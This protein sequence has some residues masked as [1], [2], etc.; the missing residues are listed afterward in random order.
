[1]L[2]QRSPTSG[3]GQAGG[4]PLV[5]DPEQRAQ[6]CDA[7]GQPQDLPDHDLR[8]ILLGAAATQRTMIETCRE[9]AAERAEAA[10]V[11]LEA[12]VDATRIREAALSST[13]HPLFARAVKAGTVDED[14]RLQW[15][16]MFADNPDAAHQA[17]TTA[18]TPAC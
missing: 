3:R 14:E 7:L 15:R 18:W 2:E 1:M 8:L 10:A 6:L 9:L 11:L 16:Q 4:R 5:F 13:F 17:L 12:R